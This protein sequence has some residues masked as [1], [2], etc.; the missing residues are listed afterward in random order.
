MQ[1][2]T[3]APQIRTAQNAFEWISEL[4]NSSIADGSVYWVTASSWS[5]PN[6]IIAPQNGCWLT[7]SIDHNSNEAYHLKISCRV[8]WGGSLNDPEWFPIATAKV[9]DLANAGRL[10]GMILMNAVDI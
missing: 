10:A 2:I 9:W 7:A 4:L 3:K 8:K 5:H 6:W 1:T